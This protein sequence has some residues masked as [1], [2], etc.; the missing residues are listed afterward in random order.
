MRE[1]G[2]AFARCDVRF[3]AGRWL[4]KQSRP[5]LVCGAAVILGRYSVGPVYFG[6]IARSI[7]DYGDDVVNGKVR[8]SRSLSLLSR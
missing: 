2:R 4:V 7:D 8:L 5:D 1:A 3:D 6:D